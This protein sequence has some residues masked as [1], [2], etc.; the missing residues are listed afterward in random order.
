MNNNKRID[1][2]TKMMS[3][4]VKNKGIKISAIS[5]GTGISYGK[6]SRSFKENRPLT[7][8]EFLLICVFIDLDPNKFKSA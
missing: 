3:D 7:V 4:Y 1:N 6:L 8:D 5:S 2:A